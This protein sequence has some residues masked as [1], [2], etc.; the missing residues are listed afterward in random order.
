MILSK[1]PILSELQ[2][3][4]LLCISFFFT[5]AILK[6]NYSFMKYLFYYSFQSYFPE[7]FLSVHIKVRLCVQSQANC[8][9]TTVSDLPRVLT[10]SN[11][12]LCYQ[13][14]FSVFFYICPVQTLVLII[15]FLQDK[16]H[17]SEYE[18]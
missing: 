16:D 9:V 3:L 17:I 6:I 12:P 18:Y 8:P 13:F 14:C 2:F 7:L 11:Q 15:F 10:G 1:L 5:F 4:Y